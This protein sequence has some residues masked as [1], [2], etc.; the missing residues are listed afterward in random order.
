MRDLIGE[1]LPDMK[2]PNQDTIFDYFVDLAENDFKNWS[3]IV[4]A[5]EPE[6]GMSY[7]A[8]V[9]PTSDT[10]RFSFLMRSL[11]EVNKPVFMTGVTGTGKTTVIEKLLSQLAPLPAD[12]GL[13]VMSTTV[14][15]S[16]QTASLVV[17]MSIEAKME[18]KR[19]NLLGAP[20]NRKLVIFVDDVN[21]PIVETYGA[22]PPVE[23]L[24]QYLD[25]KGFND[26]DKL[27]W[28]DVVDTLLF[29]CAAPPGGGRSPVTP[30]FV[31]HHNVLC[32]PPASQLALERI[33]TSI[34]S[35]HVSKFEKP[36]VELTKGAVLST[37][38]VY[39]SISHEL[40]PTPAKFHYTFNLRDISKVFQG[41]LMVTASKCNTP[42]SFY[43]LWIH[44]TCRVFYDRLI[45]R[46]D[47]VWFEKKIVELVSRHF[48]ENVDA[49]S[50]FQ[51]K[52]VLFCDF[53]RP[54]AE[55]KLYE[56]AVDNKKLSKLL[57]DGL[58]EYNSEYPTAMNL[59]FF[60][61][62]IQH[63]CRLSRI[64][65]QPRG[66]AMLVGVGGSGK[67]STARIVAFIA[68]FE[69]VTIEI[70]RGYGINEF[71]EDIKKFMWSAGVERKS[72]A[73]IFTDTQIVDETMLEDI[74]NI[75]NAGEVPNLWP[76]DELDKVVS[77]MFPI[78]KELGIIESRDNC[79]NLFVELCR[80]NLH[81]VL[82]MSPVGDALRL[83]CR[84]FPA[85]INCTTIDWFHPWPETALISVASHLMSDM[86]LP[87]GM[88]GVKEGLITMCG[89]VHTSV[90]T[91]GD[92]FYAELRRKVYTT[93]KSYLDLIQ[94]YK[95]M[96]SSN[97][98]KVED[99]RERMVIGVQKL[100]ETESLV[101]G[102]KADLTKLQ[103]VLEEKTIAADALLKSVAIDQAEADQ[104][105][106][107]VEVEEKIVKKQAA[108]VGEVA[109][110]AQL[111]L[112][113]ALPALENAVK[114]LDSLT[115]G[116]IT[117]VKSFAKP[118]EA[119]QTVMEA[120]CV[121][122]NEKQDWDAAKRVLNK[123]D[124]I[125]SMKNYDK[126]NIPQ[127]TLVKLRKVLVKEK[128]Q[129][130]VVQRV[131]K[132]ATGMA[133]W[134]HAMSVYADVSKSVEPKKKKLAEMNAQ[135]AEANAML[136]EKQTTLKAVLD[137]VDELNILCKKTVDEKNDLQ[138]QSDLTANR[139]VRAEKL[140]GGLSEEGVRWRET[141]EVLSE[142][143][144][145]LIG[146]TFL[147]CAAVSYYGPF[148][149]VYRNR[150]VDRWV[151]KTKNMDIPCNA[152]FSVDGTMIEPTQIREWQNF[153]LPTDS[154][155]TDSAILAT[156]AK[157]WPLMIDPQGQANKW[158]KKM[159][160]AQGV[161]MT[162]MSNI[163]LLRSL[164]FCIRNGR[165]LLIEDVREV[166]EP[167]L[168][169]ILQKAIY[170][171]GTRKLIRLGD[172]DVDYD[173]MFKLYMTSKLSNPHYLPETCIKVTVINF[174]VT[175]DGLEDQILGDVV[176][177]ERPDIEAKKVQLLL[178][179]ASDKKKLNEL[180]AQILHD[181][182]SSTGNILDNEQLIET[183]SNS[184][185]MSN[186]I[187]E[188]VEESE[189]TNKSI[190][191][192]REKYRS[193]ATRGSLIYFLI[194]DLAEIDPMYQVSE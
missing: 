85:L 145:L 37:M 133:M 116:D 53:L 76:M 99:Q 21:M 59:V 169:P 188:R 111:D 49:E 33:F 154:V 164:E 105:K 187:K 82:G 185:V 112:D 153:S 38:E 70:N 67:Q 89:F 41:L 179:M 149:G 101:S 69:C 43:R 62:A 78:C 13:G 104:V 73:W 98:A 177:M 143:V 130:D 72:V 146:D 90:N 16:A 24:R 135:M 36:V 18:K 114:A 20:I 115:K 166:I 162:T 2:F 118:P 75:L 96:L 14:N 161:Q 140:T 183:L 139:L 51:D 60:Q 168:E 66:N 86:E 152:Q 19:K 68:G 150:L 136:L 1:E 186:M 30:R 50:L 32:V 191:E 52:S 8:M 10:V 134:C 158:V 126:D 34:L 155:S 181:L 83:R 22:Q 46:D 55:K 4:P 138:E 95:E 180:E 58:D 6:V 80:E 47:Q 148:T 63:V 124:F 23:L 77:N 128:M 131:S 7:F 174:T 26:R 190:T 45:N 113:K 9:V 184:K 194:A 91:V 127:P 175:I 97:Q 163:N 88:D 87:S 29:S 129:I 170:K 79:I 35:I 56:E 178:S 57:N 42:T 165:P 94:L 31:R 119:V 25:H 147:A 103:P 44:E 160:E 141:V 108:E 5:F 173:D 54:G 92:D 40:L 193:A 15:F 106:A 189:K 182:S 74:N 159:E 71:R 123:S 17:Q 65:K 142:K 12:G 122:F 107:K 117:E 102:L 171:Q 109:A 156:K 100:D 93:P 172:S 125:E 120:V 110:D 84:N 151:A 121:M 137:R 64:F 81:I 11:I 39:E 192:T 48:R 157:R 3:T 61:D 27:F 132:A 167:A 28:K 176:K 144:L